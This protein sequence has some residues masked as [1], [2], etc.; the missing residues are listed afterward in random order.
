MASDSVG[1]GVIAAP[2]TK[3]FFYQL[4]KVKNLFS[5]TGSQKIFDLEFLLGMSS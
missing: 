5:N 1:I 4:V 3:N 2:C